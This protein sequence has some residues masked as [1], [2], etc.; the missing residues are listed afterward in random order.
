MIGRILCYL[1]NHN[2]R[3]TARPVKGGNN[4]VFKLTRYCQRCEKLEWALLYKPNGYATDF[5]TSKEWVVLNE[6]FKE[7][8]R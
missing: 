3:R 1:G 4:Q 6:K 5:R 2:W 8:L 7:G